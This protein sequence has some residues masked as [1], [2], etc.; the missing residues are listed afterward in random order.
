MI[1]LTHQ[2]INT[3]EV[4]NRVG[5]PLA[6]AV[7]LFLGTTRELTAGRRTASLDYE[8][9]PEMAERKLAE[10]EVEARRR[11]SLI[12]CVLVHRL[13]HVEIGAASVAIAVSS[14]HRRAAFEAG[15]WLI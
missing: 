1:E 12:E 15:Q 13:G 6:G 9:Y 14:A 11:W 8:C 2:P 7:V 3:Q 10:L 5:S 4:L